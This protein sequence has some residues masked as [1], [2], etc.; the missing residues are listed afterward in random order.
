M[1][2]LNTLLLI[3][4]TTD[5]I[6]IPRTSP[7]FESYKVNQDAVV[8]PLNQSAQYQQDWLGLKTLDSAGRLQLRSVPCGH[9]DIPRDSCKQWY[10]KY[11]KPLLNNSISARAL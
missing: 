8:V 10:D 4:S 7:W 3:Y 2:S 9:Q 5:H 6:V 11:T 1:T